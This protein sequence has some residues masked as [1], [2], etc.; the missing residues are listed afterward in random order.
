MD[1]GPLPATASVRVWEKGVGG[2]IAQ[3][4][5][6]GLLLPEDMHAFEDGTDKSLGRQLQWPLLRYPHV[7]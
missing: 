4:L 2:C 5:V 7:F 6:R 3:S 1:S